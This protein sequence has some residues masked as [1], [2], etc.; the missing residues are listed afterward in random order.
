M[1]ID[2]SSDGSVPTQSVHLQQSAP[3]RLLAYTIASS[4]KRHTSTWVASPPAEAALRSCSRAAAKCDVGFASSVSA[5]AAL[6]LPCG[7]PKRVIY[8]FQRCRRYA[9]QSFQSVIHGGS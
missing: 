5:G 3:S 2:M 9:F 4:M 7:T 1:R 8:S 6:R